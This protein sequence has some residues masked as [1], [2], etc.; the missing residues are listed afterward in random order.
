[1]TVSELLAMR[2]TP[3]KPTPP[4]PVAI[5]PPR[6]GHLRPSVTTSTRRLEAGMIAEVLQ[7]RTEL[8][9][10]L[11]ALLNW[12]R[13]APRLRARCTYSTACSRI[14]W[15]VSLSGREASANLIV[16]ALFGMICPIGRA[17]GD[18]PGLHLRT[19]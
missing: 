5:P 4:R 8:E 9:T 7:L 17:P 6:P 3:P 14:S 10:A 19:G 18:R 15:S 1:M 11:A 16:N 12:V 13:H 2:A